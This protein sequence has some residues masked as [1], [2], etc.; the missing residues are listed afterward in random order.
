M[1]NTDHIPYSQRGLENLATALG[2]PTPLLWVN[3]VGNRIDI[4]G[5]LNLEDRAEEQEMYKSQA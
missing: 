3:P 4:K 1:N 2:V 5:S